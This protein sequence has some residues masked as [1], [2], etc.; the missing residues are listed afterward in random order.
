MKKRTIGNKR[1]LGLLLLAAGMACSGQARTHEEALEWF[2]DSR[3]GIF[4]HWTSQSITGDWSDNCGLDIGEKRPDRD[5]Q[6]E[7]AMEFNPQKFDAAEWLD[8]VERA[9]A[10]Y[11][12]FTTKHVLGFCM[13]DNPYSEFD[14]MSTEFKRDVCKELADEA[15]ARDLGLFWYYGSTDRAHPEYKRNLTDPE[16][17]FYDYQYKTVELLLTKYGRIDGMWW[18][19]NHKH[20]GEELMQMSEKLQP[21]LLMTGRYHKPSGDFH[22]PEQ[23]VG[24]FNIDHPWESCIPIQGLTWMW[25]GGRD[26]KDTPTC[27]KALSQ[28]VIG[29]GNLLLNISPKPDGTLQQEQVDVLLD[30]G[31]WLETCGDAVYKTR[32]GPYKPGTWGGSCRKGNKVYLHIMQHI[33]DGVLELPALP[34]AIKSSRILTSGRFK[35]KSE[36]DK[37]IF[38]LNRKARRPDPITV[39]ELELEGDAMALDPV[40][41]GGERQTL[42]YDVVATASSEQFTNTPAATVVHISEIE[43]NSALY[44]KKWFRLKREEELTEEMK[45]LTD[46]PFEKRSRGFRLRYW[47]AAKEDPQPWLEVDLGSVKKISDV[48]LMEKFNRIRAFKLQYEKDGK[49]VTFYKGKRLNFFDLKLKEPIEAQKVRLLITRQSD[50]GPPGIKIFDLF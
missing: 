40:E 5:E 31:E 18:D 41:T 37:W 50:E 7:R 43:D 46:Y 17:P 15:R 38:K 49:W 11:I 30:M 1:K 24:A 27:L 48:H 16:S 6:I 3:F 22:T 2:Q 19:G 23:E 42:V 35:V 10:K 33:E 13:W 44:R 36:G 34:H 14:I 26:I 4:L 45:N 29:G 25:N 8:V 39:I 20:H 32:G 12:S 28:C 47:V 21:H 9:G